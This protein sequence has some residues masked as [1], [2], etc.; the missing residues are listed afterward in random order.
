LAATNDGRL[1]VAAKTGLGSLPHSDPG[2]TQILLLER[3]PTDAW[4]S[5]Q[6]SEVRDEQEDP[7]IAIDSDTHSLYVFTIAPTGGVYSRV[8]PLDDLRFTVSAGRLIVP[9]T[10]G[11]RL[12]GLAS[13]SQV[14]GAK[15][16]VVVLAIDRVD[17][18]YTHALLTL[19]H[20][21]APRDRPARA[22]A[23]PNPR[24]A[25]QLVDESFDEWTAGAPLPTGWTVRGPGIV[26]IRSTD[27]THARSAVVASSS[28]D[29]TRVCR[30]IPAVNDGT[31]TLSLDFLA[32][33]FGAGDDT[34]TSLWSGG[35][36]VVSVR[37]NRLGRFGYF[38]GPDKLLTDARATPGQWFH[39]IIVLQPAVGTYAW[40]VTTS[41]GVSLFD[42]H[43]LH[44][45]RG[46]IDRFC[47]EASAGDRRVA[48]DNLRVT[49]E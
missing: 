24:V 43:A 8:A 49:Q 10:P 27:A 13:T 38:V 18:R 46:A 36:Q 25:A 22:V 41:A 28:A 30:Q 14:V 45:Q 42:L 5:H 35:A 39:S 1:F 23:A 7:I 21:P 31:L 6:V 40:R 34:V 26:G 37:L 32:S 47:T 33:S 20:S 3:D 2:W 29:S 48:I 15:S 9:A 11:G 19:S 16:G 12:D 44:S 17:Q 4:H